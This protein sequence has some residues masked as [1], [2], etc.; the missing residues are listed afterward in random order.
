MP[1]RKLE[2]T[3]QINCLE[4][5]Y[6]FPPEVVVPRC[7]EWVTRQEF[8][9]EEVSCEEIDELY[10]GEANLDK[11]PRFACKIRVKRR[12]R[13]SLEDIEKLYSGGE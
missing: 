3:C 1:R 9:R 8:Q 12:K 2:Q 11:I 6:P 10:T 4:P 7:S 5:H 13:R